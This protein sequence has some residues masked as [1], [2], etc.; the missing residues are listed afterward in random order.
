VILFSIVEV[1]RPVERTNSS[2]TGRRVSEIDV[3][4]KY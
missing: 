2:K 4:G 3:T 1:R